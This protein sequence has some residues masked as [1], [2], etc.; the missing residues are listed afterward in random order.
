MDSSKHSSLHN[1]R[2][3]T[4][5]DDL[6]P[7][8]L[9]SQGLVATDLTS[10]QKKKSFDIQNEGN[11]ED[12]EEVDHDEFLLLEQQMREQEQLNQEETKSRKSENQSMKG[13]S[14]AT[15]DTEENRSAYE[16]P[17]SALHKKKKRRLSKVEEEVKHVTNNPRGTDTISEINKSEINKS[18]AVSQKD[19]KKTRH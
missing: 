19:A 5:N 4:E 12:E 15:S 18:A 3:A 9:K 2:S 8:N 10:Y 16:R 13:V 14:F 17:T 1:Q 6:T 11:G 7:Q